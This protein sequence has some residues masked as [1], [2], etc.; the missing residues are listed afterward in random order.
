MSEK[1]Q[2]IYSKSDIIK[3]DDKNKLNQ[4]EKSFPNIKKRKMSPKTKKLISNFVNS[5]FE[6]EK[7][8]LNKSLSPSNNKQKNKIKENKQKIL[9]N[10]N[11]FQ[12]QKEK[13]NP[14]IKR[15]ELSPKTNKNS[16]TPLINL[17]GKP[18]LNKSFS[19]VLNK[20]KEDYSRKNIKEKSVMKDRS[21]S[22]EKMKKERNTTCDYKK[23][24][25]RINLNNNQK[26][27]NN[28][29]NTE[30]KENNKRIIKTENNAK[31][32]SYR[33]TIG[34]KMIKNEIAKEKKMCAEKLKIIKDHILSLQRKEEELSKKMIQLNY[35]ENELK[36]KISKRKKKRKKK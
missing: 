9:I 31:T 32:P 21:K 2:K 13:T 11:N 24:N 35:K 17:K 5:L 33:P 36:K 15:D 16:I 34:D 14:I 19:P 30:K 26:I 18:N 7:Q 12:K 10:K 3:K 1:K 6:T 8:N 29:L 22:S 27:R 28:N 20:I 23:Y 4:K 25:I